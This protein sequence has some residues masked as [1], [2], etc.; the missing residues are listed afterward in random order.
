MAAAAA[1]KPEV[2]AL[3]L[4]CKAE[5]DASDYYGQ[6]ALYGASSCGHADC[7]NLLLAAKVSL[8]HHCSKECNQ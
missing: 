5:I 3:L 2:V 4:Q 8:L 7:V 1:G 6:R